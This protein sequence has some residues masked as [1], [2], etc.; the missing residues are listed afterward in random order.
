MKRA[1]L[2]QE[3]WGDANFHLDA[4]ARRRGY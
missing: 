2:L 1:R 4:L 3:L